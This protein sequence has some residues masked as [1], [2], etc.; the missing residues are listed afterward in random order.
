[1]LTAKDT[2][3]HRMTKALRAS[4]AA[5]RFGLT[6]VPIDTALYRKGAV[7]ER[8]ICPLHPAD[9]KRGGFRSDDIVELMSGRGAP[10][11]AWITLDRRSKPGTVPLDAY[12]RR[13]LRLDA[14][15]R[16][17]IAALR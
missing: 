1:V 11:R 10:L 6:V 13:V 9:A 4:I 12:A 7:S 17:L 16:L 8:R 3:N 2:P 15:D 5:K 14:G